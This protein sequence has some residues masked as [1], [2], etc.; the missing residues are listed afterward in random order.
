MLC[1]LQNTYPTN[2]LKLIDAVRN[3][4]HNNGFYQPIG[5]QEI[6]FRI[7]FAGKEFHFK[8]DNRVD[9]TADDIF[10]IIQNEIELIYKTLE[11][12]EIKQLPISEDKG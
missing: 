2:F 1:E 7:E 5:K 4:I 12:D 9:V 8:Q 3:S 10:N 6:E 11:V